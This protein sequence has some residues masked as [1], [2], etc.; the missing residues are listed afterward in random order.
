[1][2]HDPP[3]NPLTAIA[4]GPVGYGS[5]AYRIN[6]RVSVHRYANQASAWMDAR[7]PQLVR[8]DGHLE[9]DHQAESRAERDA[10][11]AIRRVL[12][13]TLD[14]ETSDHQYALE[15]IDRIANAA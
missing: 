2:K 5:Y 6:G 12:S 11:T 7:R 8:E 1:M 4:V 10:L 14:S 9:P 13:R 15:Q 3:V